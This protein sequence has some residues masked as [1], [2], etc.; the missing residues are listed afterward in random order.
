ML[1]DEM[2]LQTHTLKIQ[3]ISLQL[4]Q[5]F[6]VLIRVGS[7]TFPFYSNCFGEAVALAKERLDQKNIYFTNP[8]FDK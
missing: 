5:T 6:S 8:A 7:P 2:A 1:Y 4:F 3:I